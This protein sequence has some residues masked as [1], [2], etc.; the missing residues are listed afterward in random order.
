LRIIFTLVFISLL[1]NNSTGQIIVS[2][3]VLDNSKTNFVEAVRVISTGGKI[4]I[5]DSLGH[6]SISTN[7]G[8]S[9]YFVYNNKPTQKFPVNTISNI[10]QF[11]ISIHL[12]VKSKYSVLK[13]VVVFS[14]SYKYD[15]LENRQNYAEVFSF[16]KPR[17]ET[18]ITPGGGVGM[19][20]N[21][22]INMF[23]FRRNKRLQKFQ[24]RLEA[25]EKEKYVNYRFNKT[26]VKRITQL[27][28][29]ALDTFLVWYRPTYE[30]AS[31][32]SEIEFN[33]YILDASYQ[34]KR[35]MPPSTLLINEVPKVEGK[36]D[37]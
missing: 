2:G 32:S 23:R 6:Y 4:A 14:K 16:H 29:T 28:G 18:S 24:E 10:G 5:T 36:K 9:L 27:K 31:T 25:E 26:F 15:S 17:V 34:Y 11:D 13:E 1:A 21:E 19:D 30:F 37:E 35:I 12:N 7:K 20:A 22:L 33:Q 8:D 3:N